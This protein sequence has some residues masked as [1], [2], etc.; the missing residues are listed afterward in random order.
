MLAAHSII[1]KQ[2]FKLS[3]RNRM[4]GHLGLQTKGQK[5]C[6]G[7]PI[8]RNKMGAGIQKIGISSIVRISQSSMGFTIEFWEN[9][10][11]LCN[12]NFCT[13][14]QGNRLPTI[15]GNLP[16]LVMLHWR[17]STKILIGIQVIFSKSPSMITT[18]CTL[19]LYLEWNRSYEFWTKLEKEL[20]SYFIVVLKNYYFCQVQLWTEPSPISNWVNRVVSWWQSPEF[21][22]NFLPFLG[23]REGGLV[24]IV[25][26]CFRCF[27]LG[28]A[29]PADHHGGRKWPGGVLNPNSK[30]STNPS[31]F[32]DIDHKDMWGCLERHLSPL[33]LDAILHPTSIFLHHNDQASE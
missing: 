12:A 20:F 21:L 15:A 16:A 30:L 29:R 26:C 3:S 24:Y 9:P 27:T 25:F 33:R 14:F 31:G 5:W 7:L 17:R 4:R 1:L 32:Y 13:D 28:L 18:L 11:A 23:G 10:R 22:C 6:L 19:N 2:T 8:P